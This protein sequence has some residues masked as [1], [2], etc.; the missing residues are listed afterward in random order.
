MVL[1]RPPS[2]NKLTGELWT[3]LFKP[4]IQLSGDSMLF[5]KT[6]YPSHRLSQPCWSKRHHKR[7]Q[8]GENALGALSLDILTWGKDGLQASMINFLKPTKQSSYQER[9]Q[10]WSQES[11][12]TAFLA[13]LS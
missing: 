13:L 9:G 3:L 12:P 5:E 11:E 2:V 1:Y 7:L 8:E 10:K 6:K 4:Y